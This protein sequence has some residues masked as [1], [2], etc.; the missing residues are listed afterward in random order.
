M[1]LTQ[2][3]AIGF[4]ASVLAAPLLGS[5]LHNLRTRRQFRGHLES[6]RRRVRLE[7]PVVLPRDPQKYEMRDLTSDQRRAVETS[8]SRWQDNARRAEALGFLDDGSD[9]PRAS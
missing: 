4:I 5:L 2:W 3:L 7:K 6:E 8:D 9:L 1:S